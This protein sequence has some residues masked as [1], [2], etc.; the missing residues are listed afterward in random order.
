[1]TATAEPAPSQ[2]PTLSRSRRRLVTGLIVLASLI[3]LGSILSTWV[4]RQMLD[5][6]SWRDASAELIEDAQVRE[7][8]SVFLVDALYDNLDVSAGLEERLPPDL[9]GFAP[10]LAGALRQPATEAVDRLLGAP[11]IQ[12]LW[13]N[14]SAVAQEKLV[15]VLTD[16]TGFGISTGDGVVT[17]DLSQ[18]LTEVAKELGL[19]DSVLARLPSDA[20]VFTVMSSS[21]LQ[22]AQT[23]VKTI[24]VLSVWLL[25]VVLA[26]FALAI[27][28]APGARRE[29][30]R[31]VGWAFVVVGLVALVVR[32]GAGNY[33]VGQLASPSS[34][35]AS[36]RAWL[37]GTSILG[38]IG[39]AAIIYGVVAVLGAVLAGPLPVATA[40]RRWLAPM[41]NGRPGVVSLVV[42]AAFLLLVLW[43][44]TH[45]LRTWWGILLLGALIAAGVVA[46]RRQTVR[47]FPAPVPAG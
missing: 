24:K 10:T 13:I 31:N 16:A 21:Q 26:L 9:Q 20:G 6:G 38:E 22:S 39:W 7:A 43:G 33:A 30:L 12:E 17:V 44:P 8:L 34:E 32:R 46:L 29:T 37:I 3:G 42:G 15:N 36:H 28:L 5:N 45:A 2:P 19:P 41:L 14:A 1:M 18:L 35:D 4:E 47:E 25:V 27:Y 11:R 40:A 23:G